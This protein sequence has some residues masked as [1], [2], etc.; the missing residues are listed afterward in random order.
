MIPQYGA[1]AAAGAFAEVFDAAEATGTATNP[2]ATISA[3]ANNPVLRN[4]FTDSPRINTAHFAD[5]CTKRRAAN[6]GVVFLRRGK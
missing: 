4:I 3:A 2:A 1:S 5:I 6:P